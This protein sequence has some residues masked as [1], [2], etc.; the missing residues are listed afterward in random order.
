MSFCI[1]VL[2]L[3]LRIRDFEQLEAVA[4]GHAGD[5]VADGARQAVVRDEAAEIAR[6]PVGLVTKSSKQLRQPLSDTGRSLQQFLMMVEVV[7]QESLE[8]GQPAI[9]LRR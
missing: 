7:E 2:P 5:V 4:V 1:G 3:N 9:V 6:H 8:I